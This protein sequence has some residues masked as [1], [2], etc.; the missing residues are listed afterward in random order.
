MASVLDVRRLRYF[1]AVCDLGSFSKAGRYLNVAQ[2]ALSHHVSTLEGDLGVQLLMRQSRGVVRTEA[3]GR[4]YDHA[5]GILHSLEQ[6]ELDVRSLVTKAIGPVMAGLSYTVMEAIG[7][8][9]MRRMV[10]TLPDIKLRLLEGHSEI[11]H[12]WMLLGQLDLALGFSQP[13]DDRLDAVPIL[14]EELVC[15]GTHDLLG[16]EG[17]IP[18]A[19][20][21]DVRI[22]NV[23]ESFQ[24]GCGI[25]MSRDSPVLAWMAIVSPVADPASGRAPTA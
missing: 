2:S 12:Q 17:P 24:G 15:I 18:F 21:L 11:L 14:E 23:V 8:S 22:N 4:L 7:L 20:A 10:Q 25:G 5:K 16:G 19:D 9:F 3:G 13:A 1:V 6:A